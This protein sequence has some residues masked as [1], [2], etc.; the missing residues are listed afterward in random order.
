MTKQRRLDDNVL[1]EKRGV[2][3][4]VVNKLPP[5]H[6]VVG[7]QLTWGVY[8]GHNVDANLHFIVM[9]GDIKTI[10]GSLLPIALMEDPSLTWPFW[11]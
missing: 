1:P 9:I 11:V 8:V 5:L 10:I 3:H 2:G 7:V 4:V 6:H